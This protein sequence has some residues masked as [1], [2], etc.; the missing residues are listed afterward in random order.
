MKIIKSLLNFS[1]IKNIDVNKQYIEL[2][3]QGH[4]NFTFCHISYL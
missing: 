3:L 4:W 2:F 1:R